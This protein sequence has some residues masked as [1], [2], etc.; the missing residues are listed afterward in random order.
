MG[1]IQ[2]RLSHRLAAGRGDALPPGSRMPSALQ[3]VGWALRPLP[4]MD[5]CYARY[6][7]SFTLRV[8]TRRPRVFL[9]DPDHPTA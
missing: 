5:R 1:N 6:G 7:E 9:T 2:S 4:F 8:R 3:A